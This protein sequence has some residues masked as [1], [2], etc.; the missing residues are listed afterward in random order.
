M[1]R[2]VIEFGVLGPLTVRR[3]GAAV[4]LSAT[5]R[6]LTAVLVAHANRAVP[7]DVLVAALWPESPPPE[8][9][10]VVQV[11]V[12]RLRKA[13]GAGVV[14]FD[15]GGYTLHPDS[16]DAL[17]FESLVA[18]AL[19]RRHEPEQACAD[20]AE[21]WGCGVVSRALVCRRSRW[22]GC[23]S[24]VRGRGSSGVSCWWSCTGVTRPPT[25]CRRWSR[26][27]RSGSGRGR[28]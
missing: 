15:T 8:P 1:L 28:C 20:L 25:S 10:K 23:G 4:P 19:R 16:V 21:P 24:G 7:V 13:L 17:R 3:D 9:R 5:A 18:A 2:R 26:S 11:Y 22:R 6:R 27:T 12:Y 14:T